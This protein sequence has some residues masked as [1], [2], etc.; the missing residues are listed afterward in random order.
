MGVLSSP[1]QT[2]T[3]TMGAGGP[4]LSLKNS[5]FNTVRSRIGI[6]TSETAAKRYGVAT[7]FKIRGEIVNEERSGWG[8]LRGRFYRDMG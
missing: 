7:L 5:M 1:S 3:S 4:R 2:L 8:V 6:K